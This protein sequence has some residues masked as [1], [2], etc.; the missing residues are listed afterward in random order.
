MYKSDY[1]EIAS[2]IDGLERKKHK[3][4]N[5]YD[6]LKEENKW[7]KDKVKFKEVKIK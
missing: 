3:I 2:E 6:W 5:E 4:K 1:Q 7:L